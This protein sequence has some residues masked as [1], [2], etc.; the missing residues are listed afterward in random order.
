LCGALAVGVIQIPLAG[1]LP[2]AMT[3]EPAVLLRTGTAIG[4]NIAKNANPLAVVPAFSIFEI[5]LLPRLCCY[6]WLSSP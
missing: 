2:G 5:N 4:E 1:I 6:Q 3:L